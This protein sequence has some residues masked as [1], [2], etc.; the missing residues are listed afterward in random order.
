MRKLLLTDLDG[1]LV[2]GSAVLQFISYIIE[3][4]II[5]DSHLRIEW[6]ND[7]KNEELIIKYAEHFKQSIKGMF[8]T[9]LEEL[10][11]DFV[12]ADILEFYG[13][14]TNVM[15]EYVE[16][17]YVPFIISGSCDFLVKEIAKK[18]GVHGFGSIYGVDKAGKMTGA[19]DV[20]MF[21][22]AEKNKIIDKLI[23]KGFTEH[24]VGMGD[25]LSD[26][27]SIG[28]ASDDFWLVDPTEF[29]MSETNRLGVEY[30][31]ITR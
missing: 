27:T 24:V 19:V 15:L 23:F 20:P 22:G 11:K 8:L 18:L 16:S 4:E 2:D 7:M 1:T 10:A 21:L 31:V 17:G 14:S 9:D 13:N 5:P 6:E 25:T 26:S 30:N 12:N 29:T 28:I 3:R